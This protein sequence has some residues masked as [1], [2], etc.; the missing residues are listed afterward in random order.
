[1]PSEHGEER[2][3]IARW[4]ADRLHGGVEAVSNRLGLTRFHFPVAMG[5]TSHL[6]N[7][8]LSCDPKSYDDKIVAIW[9]GEVG[10]P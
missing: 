9:E 3:R 10:A 6:S 4:G 8:L 1:M 7:F 2:N 5:F